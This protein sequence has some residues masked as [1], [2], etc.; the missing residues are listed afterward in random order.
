MFMKGFINTQDHFQ[1]CFPKI[2]ISFLNGKYLLL[3]K[4]CLGAFS[5]VGL[6][7]SNIWLPSIRVIV[8]KANCFPFSKVEEEEIG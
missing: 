3:R 8:A 7:L 1:S 4:I 5:L 2:Q 6:L